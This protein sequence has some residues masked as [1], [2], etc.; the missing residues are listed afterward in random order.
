MGLGAVEIITLMLVLLAFFGLV[1]YALV[2]AIRSDFKKD[3][4]KLIWVIVIV[5]F[6]F[7]GSI[8]Y[9]LMASDQKALTK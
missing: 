7:L 8:L 9:F 5:C 6:P 2:D 3:I 1:I 4:N